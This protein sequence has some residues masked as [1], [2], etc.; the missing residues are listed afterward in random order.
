MDSTAKTLVFWFALLVAA[1]LLYGLVQHRPL[2]AAA[3]LN[4]VVGEL[5]KSRG[6]GRLIESAT[7]LLPPV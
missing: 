6:D 1:V 4:R 3:T 7:V 2:H 5:L